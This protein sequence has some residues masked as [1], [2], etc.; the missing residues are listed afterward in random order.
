MNPGTTF[1]RVYRTLKEQLTSGRFAAGERLEPAA[2]SG[3]LHA[4]VTPVRDALHRLVGERL[5]EAPRHNGFRVPALTEEQ[6]RDLYD[7]HAIMLDLAL[8]TPPREMRAMPGFPADRVTT[9]ADLFLELARRSGNGEHLA[10]VA[11]LDERLGAI[12][13]VEPAVLGDTEEE[14]AKLQAAWK[15]GDR[16]AL[17]KALRDYHRRRKAFVPQLVSASRDARDTD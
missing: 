12:R 7:W 16:A 14:W 9:P 8:R 1:E 4:S 2:L 6:L 5:V 3:D 13:A 10:A 17:R 15:I 11:G